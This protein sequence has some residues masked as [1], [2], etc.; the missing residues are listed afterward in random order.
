MLKKKIKSKNNLYDQKGLEIHNFS[1]KLWKIHRSITGPGVRQS[2]SLIKKK[3]EKVQIKSIKSETKVFDWKIPREWIINDAYILTP[4]N[5]K[6]CNFKSNFL[7]LV[8]YSEPTNKYIDLKNLKKHLHTIKKRPKAI[9][10]NT[11]YYKK[12]WGFC[13][14]YNEFKKLK[15]GKYFVKIDSKFKKGELNYGELL[16]EGKSKKEIFISTYICHPNLAN[17]EIS[18]PALLTFIAD[19]I[20]KMKNRRYSYR[21]VFVPETI[22]SIAYLSK[23]YK[24]MKKNTIAGYNLTCIG[25][26]R[27]YSYM[28]SRNGDHLSDKAAKH[29]LKYIDRNYKT[30]SWLERGSDE[31][32]YCSP[33]IDLPLCVIMRS[34]YGTY[35]EYHTSDD[36]LKD[37]VTP[38]GFSGSFKLIK[39][40]IEAIENNYMPKATIIGEPFLSKRNFIYNKL[41]DKKN[42]KIDQKFFHVTDSMKKNINRNEIFFQRKLMHCFWWCDGKHDLFD[43]ADK[44]NIPIWELDDVLKELI[45]QKLIKKK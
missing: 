35:P 41:N 23:N 21:I 19:W 2:L 40:I 5:K 44:L 38:K 34:K 39:L 26:S 45:R 30:Y 16:I 15:N 4:N 32:Q 6:I 20:L 11:S 3:C 24:G 9:P 12:N 31:R 28:P 13:I 14:S 27:E 1:K 37:V 43:I 7:H 22:G 36:N 29:V 10:Y 18:G 17:N 42:I 33:G 8:S 25:D